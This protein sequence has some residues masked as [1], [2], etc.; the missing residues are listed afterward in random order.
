MVVSE[1][2]PLMYKRSADKFRVCGRTMKAFFFGIILIFTSTSPA[3]AEFVPWSE[4]VFSYVEQEYGARAKKRLRYIYTL[5]VENQDKSQMQK[6]ALVNTYMNRLPW[7]A[8]EK[9]WKSSDYWA[10]PLETIATFGGDCEDIAIAKW[11]MLNHLGISST[12][13]RLAYVKNIKTV[14][15]HMVLLYIE[16]PKETVEAQQ[17]W[18]L[19]NYI[20]AV[21]KSSERRDLLAV[22]GTDATG[23]LVHY[24]DTGP[25]S[26][27]TDV[28]TEE[29]IKSLE[30]LKAKILENRKKYQEL[31]DGRPL[32]PND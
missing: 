26:T 8:D 20:D 4:K 29:K 27:I 30:T 14:E 28:F 24:K 5:I 21:R 2:Y 1:K 3:Y 18:V 13:L 32:L 9:H 25:E 11:I 19:D 6:L 7:I 22:F 15:S 17:F 16:N 12:N 31:N 23:N 10:T